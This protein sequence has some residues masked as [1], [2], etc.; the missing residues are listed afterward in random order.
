M[1]ELKQKSLMRGNRLQ[2]NCV[3]WPMKRMTLAFVAEQ[4]LAQADFER[5]ELN[6][7]RLPHFLQ[8]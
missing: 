3:V 2:F 4:N 8:K 6:S 1:A 5:R 7:K